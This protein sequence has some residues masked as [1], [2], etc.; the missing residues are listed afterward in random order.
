[1][2]LNETRTF[3]NSSLVPPGVTADFASSLAQT[4]AFDVDPMG[5]ADVPPVPPGYEVLGKLGEGGMGIVYKAKQ[6]ALNRIEVL[7]MIRAGEFASPLE[8]I[9][10]KFEA[11]AA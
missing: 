3:T 8:L 11:E 10:F 7:K 1:M 9:R 4:S 5:Q 2:N 6:I